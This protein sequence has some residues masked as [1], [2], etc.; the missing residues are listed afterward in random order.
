MKYIVVVGDGMAD[1]PI[2]EL[3]GKTPLMVARK[4]NMDH[5]AE[6]GC[7]GLLRTLFKGMPLSS[8]VANL[9]ILGY[10]PRKYHTGGRGP[11]EA[12][13]QGIRLGV[14][15]IAFR[16]NLV[17]VEDG[18]LRDYSGGHITTG[19]A[20]ELMGAV[21][22]EFGSPEI[23]FY[24]GVSYRN[25]LVLRSSRYSEDISCK[26]PHDVIDREVEKNLVRP[27]N[28][29]AHETAEMLNNIIIKSKRVLEEHPINLMRKK[30]G[31][32]MANMLWLWGAGR[33]LNLPKFNERFGKQ[34]AMI[35]AVDLLK[36]LGVYI[37]LEVI[38]VP[39]ATGYL[40]TNYE[41][42]ADAALSALKK[43]DLVYIHVEA[44]DEAS[45]EGSLEKK[46][47]AIEDLD[48]RLIGRLLNSLKDKEFK[49][50]V[51]ADHA[52]PI[53]E[54][55]HISDPVP[56]TIY[57]TDSSGDEV[58]SYDERSAAKGL[59]GLKEGEE[60]MKLLLGA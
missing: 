1:R 8:D 47:K 26:P 25:I 27:L 19:E 9:S 6:M 56:F 4:P 2:E 60:F 20:R 40:D 49:I 10:D 13:S 31:K 17:T 37:G 59:F 42:K 45:H 16:C 41:G 18:I 7:S 52:T 11:L 58:N 33:R 57:S 50:A 23:E 24:S 39:G 43:K 15:D 35:S 34:G 21:G 51:L 32:P 55:T 3:G 28:D 44:P 30:E 38:N 5:I 12:A 29:S 46:I 54:R 22:E 53:K 36:G 48:S 14:Q